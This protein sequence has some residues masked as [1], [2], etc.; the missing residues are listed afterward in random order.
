MVPQIL[1]QN[2]LP[3]WGKIRRTREKIASVASLQ[4][5]YKCRHMSEIKNSCY[6]LNNPRI[7]DKF[8]G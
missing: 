6:F 1:N 4:Y 7:I 3:C 5:G 8:A 2:P